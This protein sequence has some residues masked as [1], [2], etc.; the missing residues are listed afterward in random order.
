MAKDIQLRPLHLGQPLPCGFEPAF[1]PEQV[2]V[3]AVDGLVAVDGPGTVA[4]GSAA[5]DE[6]PVGQGV[7]SGW[8]IFEH[9]AG[10]GGEDTQRFL[11]AGLQVGQLFGALVADDFGEGEVDGQAFLEEP[12]LH[13]EVADDMHHENANGGAG[14]VGSGETVGKCKISL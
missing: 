7:A 6:G 11:N 12:L 14:R 8:G 9:E 2:R 4:D 1:G 10:G 13:L 3:R 5:R